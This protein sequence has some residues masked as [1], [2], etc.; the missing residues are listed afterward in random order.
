MSGKEVSRN[1]RMLDKAILRQRAKHR[2]Q[3][4]RGGGYVRQMQS[5]RWGEPG[6]PMCDWPQIPVVLPHRDSRA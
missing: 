6:L 5:G 4:P 2:D 1:E 3:A